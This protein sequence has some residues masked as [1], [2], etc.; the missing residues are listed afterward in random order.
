MFSF[1]LLSFAFSIPASVC[2]PFTEKNQIR[3]KGETLPCPR[4]SKDRPTGEPVI[5]PNPYRAF[6]IDRNDEITVKKCPE[7]YDKYD[8]GFDVEC[9]LKCPQFRCHSTFRKCPTMWTPGPERNKCYCLA[10]NA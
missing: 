9:Y 3:L 10:G 7:G 6:C 5:T 8:L 4:G 2:P 1:I